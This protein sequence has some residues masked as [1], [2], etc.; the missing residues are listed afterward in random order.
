MRLRRKPWFLFNE[1]FSKASRP[2]GFF[3]CSWWH[4]N[5]NPKRQSDLCVDS[6]VTLE[7]LQGLA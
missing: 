5:C 2:A 6:R 4:F 7:I 1:H 3:S